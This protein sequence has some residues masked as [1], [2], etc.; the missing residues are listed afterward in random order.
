MARLSRGVPGDYWRRS[1][2]LFPVAMPA[3]LAHILLIGLV[4]LV[5][6]ELVARLEDRV[7]YGTPWLSPYREPAEMIVRD[8]DGIHGRPGARFQKW[9]MNNHGFRGPDSDSL[10]APGTLRVIAAGASETYGLYE[11][12][13]REYPRQLEDSLTALLGAGTCVKAARAEVLNAAMAG[14]TLPTVAQDVRL[15]LWRFEPTVVLYYPTPS[16]YLA[17]A[18]P[19]A[20]RPDSSRRSS[21]ADGR[22]GLYPRVLDRLREQVKQ[23][24]PRAVQDRLREREIVQAVHSHPPGWQFDSLPV[25]R[26]SAYESDLRRLVG[27]IRQIGAEPVLATHGSVYALGLGVDS[28]PLRMWQRF[29]PRATGRVILAFDSAAAVR[30]RQVA[31][32]SAVGIADVARAVGPDGYADNT[33]FNDA[34]AAVAASVIARAVLETVVPD[35]CVP[36]GGDAGRE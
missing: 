28:V 27:D 32:D 17:D 3:K 30:T 29:Y 1:P 13:G 23:L 36:R 16:Q 6:M 31:R 10:P 33:H 26:L 22:T 24:L 4:T 21:P 5:A 34:G 7:R 11:S 9:V 15:R 14:M 8:A 18:S 20:A 2:F 12:P 35:D 25:D 19:T